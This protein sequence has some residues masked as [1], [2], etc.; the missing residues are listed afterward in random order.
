[1][2]GVVLFLLGGGSAAGAQEDYALSWFTLDGGGGRSGDG[3]FYL[4]ATLG[5]PDAGVMKD[6]YFT[7]FGGFWSASVATAPAITASPLD[8]L[9]Q[10]GA[11]VELNVVASGAIPLRYQWRLNGMNLAGET[12]ATLVIP[13]ADLADAGTY[14]VVV[15]NPL[16]SVESGPA[17]VELVL[18]RLPVEND[19]TN[20][21]ALAG[22]SGVFVGDN[23]NAT[24]EAGEPRHASKPGGHSVWYTWQAPATGIATFS[25][26]GSTFDT[27]LAVYVGSRVDA[28]TPIVANDDARGGLLTSE[29]HFNATNGTVYQVVVDGFGGQE[30]EFVLSW[31]LEVTNK[32]VPLISI[33]PPAQAVPL[34]APAMFSVSASGAGLTYQWYFQGRPLQSQNGPV[35]Q[36]PAVTPATVGY[37]SVA[38][39][40]SQGRGLLSLEAALE[41]GNRSEVVSFNK[42]AAAIAALADAAGS[43]GAGAGGGSAAPL[44]FA[45]ASGPV[46]FS[47]VSVGGIDGQTYNNNTAVGSAC[48]TCGVVGG[49]AQWYVLTAL[50]DGLLTLD[51]VGSAFDTVLM[52]YSNAPLSQICS[53]FIGCNNDA[54]PS[55]TTSLFAFTAISGGRYLI[56]VDGVNGAKGTIRLNWKLC[57]PPSPFQYGGS[58]FVLVTDPNPSPYPDDPNYHWKQDGSP[59][60]D[61]AAPLLS[62]ISPPASASS[63]SVDY[64]TVDHGSV[65][66]VNKP[67]GAF[68]PVTA[69]AHQQSGQ[70]QILLPNFTVSA[71]ALRLETAQAGLTNCDGGWLWL[72]VTNYVVSTQAAS[73]VLT[74]PIE[75]TNRLHRIRP[76]LP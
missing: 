29:V 59:V 69:G 9:V 53:H 30:G 40:N 22:F 43:A 56:G 42:L 73:L 75:A 24:K 51:T 20:R 26:L 2:I 44:L 31:N 54:G 47:S 3:F 46:G 76:S 58:D 18:P 49:A 74:L 68:L 28:L 60:G 17:T 62:M 15:H 50:G 48:N 19:F 52:V 57:V 55:I 14:T 34:G 33:S 41:I 72:P 67:L 32:V 63:F 10:I 25:T 37:Y 36:I 21:L 64:T 7:L 66:L 71:S 5:Q 70:F 11:P 8:Q 16:G 61:T 4:E 23:T 65:N 45:P 6:D 12:N 1:M 13:Q 27:L 39:T 38:V 35:L